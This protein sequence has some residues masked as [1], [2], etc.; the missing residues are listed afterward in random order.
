MAIKAQAL[1][2][3]VEKFTI[4][5][6]E[7]SQDDL[8]LWTIHTN[9]SSVMD[10]EGV[11]VVLIS[12]EWDFFKYGVQLN[13]L[14]TNNE[15]EYE[16]MLTGLRVAKA[17]G[18]KKVLLKSDSQLMIGQVNNGYESK[19]YK[20][21]KYL[22]LTNQLIGHFKEIRF[23]QISGAK[24]TGADEIARLASSKEEVERPDLKIE[25]QKH[26][27]IEEVHIFPIQNKESWMTPI[28]SYIRNGELP[29]D[30][31]EAERVKTRSSRFTIMSDEL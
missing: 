26:P 10:L 14:A 28:L 18:A 30:P 23:V 13:F 5:N 31:K 8:D 16:A 1:A 11:G 7:S 19:E 20:M 3:F 17:I 15:T 21:Q 25:V 9:G 4:P 6:D 22:K 29:L 24:K 27:S 12:L 2:D